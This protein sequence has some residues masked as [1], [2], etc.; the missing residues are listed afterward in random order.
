MESSHVA[1]INEA[2]IV[3]IFDELAVRAARDHCGEG[4]ALRAAEFDVV[5]ERGAEAVFDSDD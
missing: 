3:V 4:N 2:I 1:R 5:F